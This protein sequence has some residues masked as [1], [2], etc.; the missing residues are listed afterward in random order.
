LKHATK[1]QQQQQ[2]QQQ[3]QLF[4]QLYDT[5]DN[6]IHDNK[7]NDFYDVYERRKKPLSLYSLLCF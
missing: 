5:N 4:T 3:R 2:Q 6:F 1:E 7:N